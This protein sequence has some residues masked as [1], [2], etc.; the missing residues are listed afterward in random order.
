MV[1]AVCEMIEMTDPFTGKT[2]NKSDFGMIIVAVD[3]IV[4]LLILVFTWF[5]ELG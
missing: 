3:V 2:I 5:L 1:L 4:V